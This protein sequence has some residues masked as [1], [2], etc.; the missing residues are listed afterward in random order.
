MGFY[1]KLAFTGHR[2]LGK[3]IDYGNF[4]KNASFTAKATGGN[5]LLKV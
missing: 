4:V 1:P 3:F 2:Q 5:G